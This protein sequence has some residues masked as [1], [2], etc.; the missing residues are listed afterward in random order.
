MFGDIISMITDNNVQN[1]AMRCKQRREALLDLIKKQYPDKSGTVFLLAPIEGD[2]QAFIQESSFYYFSGISEPATVISFAQNQPTVFY[3]PDFGSL[4]AKWID[5]TY[6]IN[7][8][9]KILYGIDEL[10]FLGKQ[11]AGYH[12]DPYFSQTDYQTLIEHL[13]DMVAQKKTIFT[14]YPT[15]SRMYASAKMVLDRLALFVP[16]LMHCVIDVSDLVAKLRK[17]KDMSEIELMYQATSITQAAFQAATHVI[18]PDVNEAQVQAAI[19]YI[20]TENGAQPAYT[21]I[22]GGGL[23]ATILHYR[24][25][26]MPLHAGDLVLIDA[27]AMFEHYCSD[28][29]R[30]FPVSGKFNKEQKKLYEIVLDTQELVAEHAKPG[31]W[32][33]NAK[34]QD[35]SLQHIAINFL[36]KQGYDQYFI[37]S[38]GHHLGLDVHDAASKTSQLEVGD[39]IT[40]E[41][42][43]Y[44]PAKSIGIRIEDNY[45]VVADGAPVCMSEDIPKS[46]KDVEEMVKQRF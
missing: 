22:V 16:G 29:T 45:W 2:H 36:K 20:F 21:T 14:L 26:N 4:R 23:R 42:G 3:Q 10:C 17:K 35:I 5:S 30:V 41:P 39:V 28:I 1:I 24:T 46:V 32:L 34:E 43:V 12:V 19:E 37:H 18:K 33:S 25:N 13:T 6:V 15:H 44:I 8:Q 9:T 31:M 11:I 27:G 7:N 38:I 40:I